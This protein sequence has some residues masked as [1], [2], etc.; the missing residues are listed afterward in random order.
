MVT[1][2]F[3]NHVNATKFPS[4][5]FQKNKNVIGCYIWGTQRV[6]GN[7]HATVGQ[8]FLHR[9]NRASKGHC[10]DGETDSQCATT[11]A[12][13]VTCLPMEITEYL[14]RNVGSLTVP[15]E[16]ICDEQFHALKN[17]SASLLQARDN[18]FFH[19]DDN[20]FNSLNVSVRVLPNLK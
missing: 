5:Q 11:Q 13:S 6:W 7:S 15:V 19:R 10:C 17:I 1:I 8:K 16:L 18:G 12:I 3:L 14:C 20:L 2:L 9:Q 4:L